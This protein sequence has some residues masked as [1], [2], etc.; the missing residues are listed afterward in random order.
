MSEN[1]TIYLIDG[2][3][4]IHRA[5]HAVRGLTNSTGLPT[6]AVFGVTRMLKKLVDEEQPEMLLVLFTLAAIVGVAIMFVIR[7]GTVQGRALGLAPDE[8]ISEASR[9]FHNVL[10]Y[11]LPMVSLLKGERT[12]EAIRARFDGWQIEDLWLPYYAV[13]SDLST[14][15]MTEIRTGPRQ[16]S[17]LRS[18]STRAP[19]RSTGCAGNTVDGSG[20]H[21]ASAWM[22]RNS[23][24]RSVATH[25]WRP[26]ARTRQARNASAS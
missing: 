25:H 14:M 16:A 17:R 3:A 2:S 8:L 11:T 20:V 23:A 4:Y 1:N 5:Y 24:R 19:S 15:A 10:D 13:A 22:A 26:A 21:S 18:N 6:N 7:L 12:S 9:L